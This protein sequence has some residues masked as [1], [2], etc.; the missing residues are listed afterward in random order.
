MISGLWL[1][2]GGN[3]VAFYVTK[4]PFLTAAL[5]CVIVIGAAFT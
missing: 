5:V 4:E 1:G 2:A 3:G